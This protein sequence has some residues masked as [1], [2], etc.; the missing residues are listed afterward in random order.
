M[1]APYSAFALSAEAER[2]RNAPKRI[3]SGGLRYANP[4]YG[5]RARSLRAPSPYILN[6]PNRVSSTGAFSA[7]LKAKASTRRVSDGAMMPSSHKRAV[8]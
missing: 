6:T 2:R 5:L 8:A 3:E 1:R 4:P 7:A